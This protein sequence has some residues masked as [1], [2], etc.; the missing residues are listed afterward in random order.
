MRLGLPRSLS[1]RLVATVVVLVA[2]A[3]LLVAG[4]TTFAMRGYLTSQLDQKVLD[5]AHRAEN[6]PPDKH[7]PV[8]PSDDD[9]GLGI[10][11]PGTLIA[12]LGDS[13]GLI[14]GDQYGEAH[15]LSSADLATLDA[16][17]VD[18]QF[19]E[20][21]L[22]EYGEYRVV[23]VDDADG[24]RQLVSGLPTHDLDQT[25]GS[26]LRWELLLALLG[27]LGAAAIGS[28]LVRR[29]MRPLTEVAATAHAVAATPLHSGEIGITERVPARLTDE[30]TEVGQ[31]GQALN[32]LLA[33]VESSLDARHRSE[34]QVRQFVA[35]ASHELRTPLTTIAGYTELARR[36]PDDATTRI[37]LAKV[38]EEASR[39]TELVEDL[40]LLAR[41]DAGRPLASEAVDLSRLLVEAVDD[42]RVV[43]PDHRWLVELPDDGEPVEVTGDPD[44]LHQ[45]ATNLLTNARKHTPAGTTVTVRVRPGGFDVHDDG[46]G[47]GRELSATAFERFTRGDAARHREGGAGLGLSLVEA[48]VSAHGGSVAL[49][50]RPGDTTIRVDLPSGERANRGPTSAPVPS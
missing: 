14:F 33:H 18:D 20:V 19:H 5:A 39:M 13:A 6:G 24:D 11:G 40:L 38:E 43:A 15:R 9:P 28:A 35:D 12:D 10:Q 31:V 32:T 34:Q 23:V 41:L 45:V 1:A 25:I 50:S 17:P 47:F 42:A 48:I 30:R 46:P 44:R 7:E 3:S 29:Q 26:L 2:V 36:R 16:V 4:A 22:G 37:A 8:P 49:D 21:S 27:V